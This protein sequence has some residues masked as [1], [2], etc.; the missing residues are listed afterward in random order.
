MFSLHGLHGFVSLGLGYQ[1]T[2]DRCFCCALLLQ[3]L[4]C[5]LAGLS[6]TLLSCVKTDIIQSKFVIIW[7]AVILVWSHHTIVVK[8]RVSD[9]SPSTKAL[10]TDA[11]GL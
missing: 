7:Y 5:L 10:N 9:W 2:L 8:L 1:G 4:F 11:L 3:R 6:V